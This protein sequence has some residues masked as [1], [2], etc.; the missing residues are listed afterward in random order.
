MEQSPSEANGGL[1]RQ[2]MGSKGSSLHS[3]EFATERPPEPDESTPSNLVFK[4]NFNIILPSI[5][6]SSK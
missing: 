6:W 1:A 5:L 3:Q 2:E 4:M